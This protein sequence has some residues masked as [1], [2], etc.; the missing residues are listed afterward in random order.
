MNVQSEGRV[1]A[2]Q[3]EVVVSRKLPVTESGL[4]YDGPL[5]AD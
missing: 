2:S 3:S 1:N 5:V 4:G